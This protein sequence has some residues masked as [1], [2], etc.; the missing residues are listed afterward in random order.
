[1]SEQVNS[2]PNDVVFH[3]DFVAQIDNV[4]SLSG[5][6]VS[7]STA[8]L[9]VIS[10]AASEI[11]QQ[12]W[13]S[14]PRPDVIDAL[15]LGDDKFAVGFVH[16]FV[17]DSND[18]QNFVISVNGKVID[19]KSLT[20]KLLNN[21]DIIFAALDDKKDVFVE[22]IKGF[23]Q[24]DDAVS[25]DKSVKPENEKQQINFYFDDCLVTD[26]N[27]LYFKGWALTEQ[28][29]NN[30]VVVDR[31][32]QTFTVT[33]C[34]RFVRHDLNEQ[35]NLTMDIAA[36][37]VSVC[38]LP[39]G[40]KAVTLSINIDGFESLSAPVSL[41]SVPLSKSTLLKTYLGLVDVHLDDF[42]SSGQ[43]AILRHVSDIWQAE[44]IMDG[45]SPQVCE[46]GEQTEQPVVSLVIPIY[47]RYDFVQHQLLAFSQ[48]P[49]MAKHEIIYVLDDPK[50]AREFTIAC[51]GVFNTFTMPFKTVYAGKNLGFA[52][53]NNL[54]ASQAQGRFILAL[55][56]DV[57]PSRH[58]W[59]SRL[60]NKYDKLE[61]VGILGTKLVYEDNTLQHIGMHFQQDAYYPGIWMN[62]HPHKGMPAKLVVSEGTKA[63]ELVTGACMLIE[64]SLYESV[65]GFDTRYILG[66][67]EDS[68]L[69]LK[70]Y[71]Q[72]KKIYLDTEESLIHLERLSQN[73]V[74]SGDWKYKLT[75]LNGLYQKNKWGQAIEKVKQHYA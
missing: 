69:C 39:D 28:A 10:E 50:I 14:I 5:W 35:L 41:H 52:G 31:Q 54:G 46:Y 74:D 15:G 60:V 58:G 12:K 45:L 42:F 20:P 37:F 65:G 61:D 26:G 59:L 17:S 32:G 44:A 43:P 18:F 70:V 71:D 21:S 40:F 3:V 1:M 48:D 75:L 62:Y 2:E 16:C 33:E 25:R 66:D 11:T 73:L 51:S 68:D 13:Q 24:S 38:R 27:L 22:S 23:Y 9:L 34:F 53:A 6:L 29:L 67:F 8:P 63:V 55:N 72:N 7:S 36:G 47:G 64:R 49:D 57:L 30:I 56:S 4:W 19:M